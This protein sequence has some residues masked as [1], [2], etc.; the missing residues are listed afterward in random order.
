LRRL[1]R[2]LSSRHIRTKNLTKY[3]AVSSGAFLSGLVGL[4]LFLNFFC[5]GI[6]LLFYRVVGGIGEGLLSGQGV[7]V[8]GPRW[9]KARRAL[10]V[11]L[12]D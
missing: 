4:D 9:L 2:E 5:A 6:P 12:A 10:S 7:V 11:I 8:E 1:V 3:R